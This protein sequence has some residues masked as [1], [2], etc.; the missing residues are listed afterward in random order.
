MVVANCPLCEYTTKDV[1]DE[2][3]LLL[4]QTHVTIHQPST[5]TPPPLPSQPTTNDEDLPDEIKALLID[6]PINEKQRYCNGVVMEIWTECRG[7]IKSLTLLKYIRDQKEARHK[8]EVKVA[9]LEALRESSDSSKDGRWQN[10]RKFTNEQFII[11]HQFVH[12]VQSTVEWLEKKIGTYEKDVNDL[13][14]R[15]EL[16]GSVGDPKAH[17]L[18]EMSFLD[19]L[20]SKREEC[21]SFLGGKKNTMVEKLRGVSTATTALASSAEKIHKRKRTIE[22]KNRKVSEAGKRVFKQAVAVLVLMG[23]TKANLSTVAEGN[24]LEV[25]AS[26][27]RNVA[28]VHLTHR[29]HL[30]GLRYMI[31]KGFFEE[32]SDLETMMVKRA[33]EMERKKEGQAATTTTR[34]SS[35]DPS[36][37]SKPFFSPPS[38]RISSAS[39]TFCSPNSWDSSPSLDS[40][41]TSCLNHSTVTTISPLQSAPVVSTDVCPTS[42]RRLSFGSGID[43][44]NHGPVKECVKDEPPKFLIFGCYLGED[45]LS[46]MWPEMECPFVCEDDIQGDSSVQDIDTST[47]VHD[48]DI[49]NYVHEIDTSIPNIETSVNNT[50]TSGHSINASVCDIDTS[51]GKNILVDNMKSSAFDNSSIAKNV[52]PNIFDSD[53]EDIIVEPI[54]DL[55]DIL[56]LETP[57]PAIQII[58]EDTEE[59]SQ[60][61]V[62]VTRSVSFKSIKNKGKKRQ[63]TFNKDY[64]EFIKKKSE[65]NR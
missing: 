54:K 7:K 3:A 21:V 41:S 22:S 50:D 5:P 63:H 36:K 65:S 1:A 51:A 44:T 27:V 6:D 25:T 2:L 58:D 17:H 43:F 9:S 49:D 38:S 20:R 62:L 46:D 12:K 53:E 8:L 30:K 15:K 45:P 34:C 48:I 40:S 37:A 47:F 57:P 26:D 19:R 59:T 52:S 28:T 4:M 42:S 13:V 64:F 11:T 24:V 14:R 55:S 29:Y 23:Y 10:V 35:P 61:D 18:N 33:K 32:G 39:S 56:N 31:E 60:K 16:L